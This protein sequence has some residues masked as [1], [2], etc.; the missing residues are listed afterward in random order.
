MRFPTHRSR[1]AASLACLVLGLSLAGGCASRFKGEW[2]EVR[3]DG[4]AM[5]GQ[6]D[7]RPMALQFVP[8]ATVRSGIYDTRARTVDAESVQESQ[9]VTLNGREIAQFGVLTA[10]VEDNLL[11]VNAPGGE[12]RRLERVKGVF[13]PMVSLRLTKATGPAP[14]A[15]SIM[16][17]E[18]TPAGAVVM[19]DAPA[20]RP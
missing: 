13:P 14:A 3:A 19:G 10:R 4:M 5:T 2:V 17:A 18:P 20:G 7:T 11:I 12:V 6:V 15:K 16:A 8:P 1:A 9:Y